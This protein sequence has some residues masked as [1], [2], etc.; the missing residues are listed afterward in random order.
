VL[1][2]IFSLNFMVIVLVLLTPVLRFVG[3]VVGT[4]GAVLSIV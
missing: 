2:L 4:F 3:M 1:A